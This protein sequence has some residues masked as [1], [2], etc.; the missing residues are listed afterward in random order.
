MKV[1]LI[2]D[3]GK[4]N[5]KC[6]LFDEHY[7][8]VFKEYQ[9][10]EEIKDEDG[11]PCDDLPRTQQWMK[12]VFNKL[13]N[14]NKYDIQAINCSG[15]GASF[16]HIDQN[17]E[18]VAPLYN[19]LKPLPEDIQAAF[20]RQYGD[21]LSFARTTA[22][23][24]LG[25]LNSGLQLYWLKHCKPEIFE[26]VRWSLHFPQYLS[27]LFTR[28]PVSDYTSIG[29]HTGLWDFTKNDYHSWVYAEGIDRN[30]APIVPTNTSQTVLFGE[31]IIKVGAGIHDSSAA[32]LPY[33]LSDETPFL[34]VSTGTWSIALNPFSKE[35]LSAEDLKHDCLN[36]M[37]IDGQ[38]VRAA[39]LFL[40]NEYKL[41]VKKLKKHYRI[42]KVR[43]HQM[44]FDKKLYQNLSSNNKRHFKFES[45]Q[46]P[47]EGPISTDLAN[48]STF[49]AA[50]HQLMLELVELQIAS[51]K[52]AIGNT[53]IEKIYIDGGFT[54]NDVYIQLLLL[55][56]KNKQLITANAP[57]GSALGA[58]LVMRETPVAK[59]FLEKH[60][61][62]KALK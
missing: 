42:E 6:F 14:D 44:Q 49:K 26:Q 39:R 20:Y 9:V 36:F 2:F 24:Q 61:A 38:V 16:V 43:H 21:E 18:L 15:H 5:K 47:R 29:C 7:Q 22:S 8:Q 12:A 25:M 28:Q 37:R 4:T 30:L 19:Y 27:Y 33:F 52:R 57:L 23:P 34:L 41:Q 50:Y 1:T 53:P 32:L 55:H 59:Q 54:K 3:I 45:I 51:A 62:L 60:Y 17:G 58:A 46:L 56:F 10:V 13:L 31:K 11:F 35:A 40:G 48:F